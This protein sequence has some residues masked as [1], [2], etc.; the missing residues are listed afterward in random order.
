MT[1]MR[2]YEPFSL[3]GANFRICSSHIPPIKAEIKNQR[4]ILIA[5]I[6]RHPQFMDALEPVQLASDPPEIVKQ[7]D[8]A[9]R[10]VG[11]G[12][13]ASVAGIMAQFA[14]QAGLIAGATEAIVE[15]GGDIY[16]QSNKDVVIGIYAKASS[17]SGKLAFLLKPSQM[18]ISICS[19]SSQMGHS[20]SFGDCNLATVFSKN[21]ALADAAAT[22]ACNSVKK[23]EDVNLVLESIVAISGVSGAL[24]IKD[25]QIGFAGDL[26]ELIKITDSG[27]ADKITVDKNS[28]HT[29]CLS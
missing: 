11:I 19:S 18:P 25:E 13:M 4:S 5:Y 2:I 16:L 15:N 22:H 27:L 29:I 28:G 8:F 20:L 17:L 21:A 3:E 24:I 10:Q 12:P 6:K 14:A 26:P 9:S 7:M 23:P 1:P